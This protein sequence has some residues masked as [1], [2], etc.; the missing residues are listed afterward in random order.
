MALNQDRAPLWEA[1]EDFCLKK[2]VSF[3]TP[4]HK[5]GKGLAIELLQLAGTGFAQ[6]DLTELPGLDNLHFPR[7]AIQE[8]QALAAQACG[9]RHSFFLVNGASCGI[10]AMVLACCRPGDKL[11]IPRDAHVSVHT[12]LIMSGVEPVYIYP[13]LNPSAG[14]IL[15]IT[16]EHLHRV[17]QDNPETRA[18]LLLNPNYYGVCSDLAGLVQEARNF[19]KPVLVDEAHG[20]HLPFHPRLPASAGKPGADLWVQSTHKMTASLTQ[21]ALLHV[22]SDRIDLE[23]LRA[24]LRM[25]QSTSPS[26]LLM[27]SLDLSRRQMATGGRQILDRLLKWANS[28]R[29]E[30]AGIPGI[31]CFDEADLLEGNG[32]LWDPLKLLINFEGIGLKGE[33]A[34]HILRTVFNLECELA[35]AKNV[36]FILAPGNT[37][38]DCLKL[39]EACSQLYKYNKLNQNNKL[40]RNNELNRTNNPSLTNQSDPPELFH[41][42]W[43]GA[44]QLL[45]PRDAWF[46]R[47]KEVPL[48]EAIGQA[49]GQFVIPYPPGIPVVCPG[50]E[51]TAEKAAVICKFEDRIRIVSD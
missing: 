49:A 51:I 10:Q 43:Q 45:T 29:K 20:A 15:G 13:E 12:A 11:I 6:L 9:A 5:H 27:A 36:L 1:L 18:V 40:N 8:A 7:G 39:V 34:A 3:H 30:L 25:V 42:S 38:E 47:G 17:L 46:A 44:K 16:R 4:G 22:G 41:Y 26:Y 24:A 48:P 33:E 2:R 23:R 31:K 37:E 50:E 32:F 21:S 35:D 28:I 19:G 14:L